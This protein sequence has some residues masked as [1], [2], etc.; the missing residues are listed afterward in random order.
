MTEKEFE[1][2]CETTETGTI[3]TFS[4]R[5]IKIEGKFIGCADDSVIVEAEGR[6]YIWPRELC[7]YRKSDYPTPSYS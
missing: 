7:L 1:E 5:D 4:Y 3:L 2:L 6:Q